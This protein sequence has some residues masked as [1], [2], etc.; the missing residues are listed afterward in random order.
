MKQMKLI[1]LA[2]SADLQ[3]SRITNVL[4]KYSDV[5]RLR[6]FNKV[7]IFRATIRT[8]DLALDLDDDRRETGR[9]NTM[10]FALK[11]LFIDVIAAVPAIVAFCRIELSG[12]LRDFNTRSRR[13][14]FTHAIKDR[15]NEN[16]SLPIA[17]RDALAS[18]LPHRIPGTWSSFTYLID[19][20]EDH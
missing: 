10:S 3:S 20:R 6:S 11:L 13:S 9:P 15:S 16:I 18:R 1:D 2:S 19:E 17:S 14:A 7:T 5:D 8:E 4:F 12:D